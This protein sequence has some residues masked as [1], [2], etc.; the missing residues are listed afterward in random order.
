[1]SIGLVFL[2]RIDGWRGLS[3]KTS[4]DF[5]ASRSAFL[6]GKRAN[7]GLEVGAWWESNLLKMYYTWVLLGVA[8]HWVGATGP[9]FILMQRVRGGSFGYQNLLFTTGR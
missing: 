8:R 6:G 4:E 9:S 3:R 7:F 5:V 2:S 1:M